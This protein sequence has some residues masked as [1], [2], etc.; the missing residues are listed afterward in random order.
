MGASVW[1]LERTA[2][3]RLMYGAPAK[4]TS[5]NGRAKEKKKRWIIVHAQTIVE[6]IVPT[7]GAMAMTGTVKRGDFDKTNNFNTEF[8]LTTPPTVIYLS[9]HVYLTETQLP[10]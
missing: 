9:F 10:V 5:G 3:D 7:G 2:E 1:R 4:A 8:V 6:W